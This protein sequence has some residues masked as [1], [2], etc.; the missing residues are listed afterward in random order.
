[1][2]PQKNTGQIEDVKSVIHGQLC[3]LRSESAILKLFFADD[4][5]KLSRTVDLVDFHQAGRTDGPTAIFFVNSEKDD[6]VFA[7][8]IE[9]FFLFFKRKKKARR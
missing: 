1:M 7:E 5:P 3:G 8:K 2:H 6:A 9:P 4:N